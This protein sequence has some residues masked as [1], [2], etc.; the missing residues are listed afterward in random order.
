MDSLSAA[1]TLSTLVRRD[2]KI[3]TPAKLRFD[4][5]AHTSH[6]LIFEVITSFLQMAPSKPSLIKK[7]LE[8]SEPYSSQLVMTVVG[9]NR[10]DNSTS[11]SSCAF[12]KSVSTVL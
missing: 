10:A 7:S 8:A 1:A 9:I 6:M 12:Q 11:S 4:T 2:L 5:T 3:K